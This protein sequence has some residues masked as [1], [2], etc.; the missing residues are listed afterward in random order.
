MKKFL[1][2]IGGGGHAKVAFDVAVASNWDIL[3]FMDDNPEAPLKNYDIK[4]LGPVGASNII[5]Q[6]AAYFIAIGDNNVRYKIIRDL[7]RS[8]IAADSDCRLISLI[9]PTAVV[10]PTAVIS[11]GV[12]LAPLT[13]VNASAKVGM[14]AIIN[15]S[16][17]IEHDCRVGVCA[18]IAPG[19]VLGGGAIVGCRSL[20]GLGANL[21]PYVRVGKDCIVGA[22]SVV[23]ANVAKGA[24]VYGV[25]ARQII[26]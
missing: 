7:T 2:I 21:L 8:N 15:T 23:V 5:Q 20:A 12:L 14:G 17:V 19:A 11:Q 18:H 22:G 4:Y 6:Q 26:N 25:P 3:G 24:V 1:I 9:H 10:S 16:A 13:V